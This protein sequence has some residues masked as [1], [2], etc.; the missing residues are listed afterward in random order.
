MLPRYI[1]KLSGSL[2][3]GEFLP[4]RPVRG[5]AS[6]GT[7]RRGGI[8]EDEGEGING[9]RKKKP[10]KRIPVTTFFKCAFPVHSIILIVDLSKAPIGENVLT[11]G[12][13]WSCNRHNKSVSILCICWL[14][15]K[16]LSNNKSWSGNYINLFILDE[17]TMEYEQINTAAAV[18]LVFI[19]SRA[20]TCSNGILLLGYKK[21]S[22]LH[23]SGGKEH[24]FCKCLI[25]FFCAA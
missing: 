5:N 16:V 4:H 21:N 22:N 20:Q 23:K 11:R 13:T 15:K 7:E 10:C 2:A 3:P 24:M 17:D 14:T 9:L 1:W 8:K 12:E 19:M 18:I 6:L 25:F